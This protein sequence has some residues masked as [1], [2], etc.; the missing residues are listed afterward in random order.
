MR[1]SSRSGTRAANDALPI[2][3]ARTNTHRP[4]GPR[5][6]RKPQTGFTAADS[7]SSSK[8]VSSVAW[9]INRSGSPVSFAA[10]LTGKSFR[11]RRARSRTPSRGSWCSGENRRLRKTSLRFEKKTVQGPSICLQTKG[12]AALALWAERRAARVG[13]ANSGHAV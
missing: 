13:F 5:A 4:D 7:S 8:V 1:P 11:P 10:T 12:P 3:P 6:I 2:V 9:A